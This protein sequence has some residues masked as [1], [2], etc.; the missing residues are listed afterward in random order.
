MSEDEGIERSNEDEA[1]EGT[2]HP[3]STDETSDDG[4]PTAV[5]SNE[6]SPTA[7]PVHEGNPHQTADEPDGPQFESPP[8]DGGRG[9]ASTITLSDRL[10]TAVAL[11]AFGGIAGLAIQPLE[12]LGWSLL[13]GSIVLGALIVG[14]IA[15]RLGGPRV[16]E[17]IW[18]GM[19]VAI[20]AAFL[21]L[22]ALRIGDVHTATRAWALQLA[23]VAVGIAVAI[24]AI[25]LERT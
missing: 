15:L 25:V 11:I 9:R 8:G 18:R 14:E 4:S 22:A 6:G 21:G 17:P 13:V 3:L 7:Q 1:A 23:T 10:W 16:V 12:A 2:R 20:F 19:L 24:G 5:S